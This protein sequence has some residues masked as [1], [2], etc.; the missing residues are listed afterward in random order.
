LKP[1]ALTDLEDWS[2]AQSEFPFACG[3]GQELRWIGRTMKSGRVDDFFTSESLRTL[4]SFHELL[5]VLVSFAVEL[6]VV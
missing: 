4:L 6:G 1:V 5:S 2:K 3:C